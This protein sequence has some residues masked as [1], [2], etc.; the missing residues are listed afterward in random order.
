M[1]NIVHRIGISNTTLKEVYN[2]IA[3]REGI[4]S[5]WT[6]EV[7]GTSEVGKV[8]EFRFGQGGPHFEVLKLVPMKMVEWKCVSGPPEWMDTHIEF[9]IS[10]Q[11]DEIVLLFKHS[12]WKIEDEFMYHCSTQW[13]YFLITLKD[14]LAGIRKA[15]PFGSDEYEP[16]STWLK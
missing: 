8:L 3:T 5:W 2:A 1:L 4:A 10:K 7:H 13:G 15:K 14:K 16:I 12:G 6:T 11:D 9:N